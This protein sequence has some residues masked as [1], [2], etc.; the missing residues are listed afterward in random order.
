MEALVYGMKQFGV[1]GG[2]LPVGWTG[3]PI[4]GEWP[5]Q[6]ALGF[7]NWAPFGFLGV[8]AILLGGGDWA[9]VQVTVLVSLLP[10]RELLQALLGLSA[11][12]TELRVKKR[13]IN[14]RPPQ[15]FHIMLLVTPTKHQ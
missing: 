8:L 15:T 9:W 4:P 7:T 14:T 11:K 12:S 2:Y 6:W 10:E 13:S 1:R 3:Q 5:T